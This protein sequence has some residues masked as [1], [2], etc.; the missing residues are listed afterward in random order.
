MDLW[1]PGNVCVCVCVCV[2]GVKVCK[3]VIQVT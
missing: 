1:G 3:E 2:F